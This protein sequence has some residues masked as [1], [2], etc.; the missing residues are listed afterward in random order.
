M[1]DLGLLLLAEIRVGRWEA[2]IERANRAVLRALEHRSRADIRALTAASWWDDPLADPLL[3]QVVQAE[4]LPVARSVFGEMVGVVYDLVPEDRRTFPP[5]D[6]ERQVDR[7]DARV[8]DMSRDV[9]E[10]L[11]SSLRVGVQRGESVDK[12]S[13]RVENIF[14]ASDV[15]ARRIARTET[16]SATNGLQNETAVGLSAQGIAMQ[17][18]WL[19]TFDRRTRET[20]AEANGQTVAMDQTFSVGGADLE[21]PGDPNGPAAEV[22]NCRCSVAYEPV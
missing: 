10:Q 18:R 8:R 1:S 13:G 22:V 5:P 6:F 17:K 21:F 2:K 11:G 15:R 20:H 19:A 4:I 16:I 3:D 14:T 12:L 9:A 7:L